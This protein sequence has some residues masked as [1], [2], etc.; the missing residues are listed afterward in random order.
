MRKVLITRNAEG[1]TKGQVVNLSNNDAH[2]FIDQENAV[3]Y[4]PDKMM[5]QEK[6]KP[7]QGNYHTK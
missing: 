2:R 7:K 5:R 4:Y 3:L 6:P 1:Y